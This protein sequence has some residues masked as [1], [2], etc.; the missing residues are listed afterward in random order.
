M[1]IIAIYFQVVNKYFKSTNSNIWFFTHIPFI[2]QLLTLKIIIMYKI[3]EI[4][5]D[6]YHIHI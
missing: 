1:T 6:L 2:Y 3:N 4:V 5:P